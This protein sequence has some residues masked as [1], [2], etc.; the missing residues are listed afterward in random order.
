MMKS[1][2]AAAIALSLLAGAAHAAQPAG[3]PGSASTAA[4]QAGTYM[5]D[6][7]HT[8]VIWHVNHMGFSPLSGMFGQITGTLQLDPARPSAATVQMEI[9][10]SGLVVTSPAFNQHLRTPDLFDE[11]KFPTARFVS[12]SV[13]VSGQQATITGDLTMHGVTKPVT[14]Q[15]RFYGTGANPQNKKQTVGFTATTKLKRS[16]FG[17]GFAVP[18]VADEVDL[19]IAAAFEK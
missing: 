17:L 2:A 7:N 6:P 19:D 14:L 1:Y 15:A 13:Q 12:K 3:T 16:D 5:A 11:A 10:V 8:Q 9:P 18:V 4:V